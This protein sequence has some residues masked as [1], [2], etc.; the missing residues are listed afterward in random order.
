MIAISTV[1]LLIL[2]FMA[3]R[4]GA[5]MIALLGVVVGV[6]LTGPLA[7]LIESGVHASE[8]AATTVDQI[9]R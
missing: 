9:A 5:W 7:Q 3:W 4:R 6:M 2:V 1:L 8:T